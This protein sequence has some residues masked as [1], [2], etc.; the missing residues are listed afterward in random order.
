MKYTA[1]QAAKATGVATSTITNALKSG[2]I[3]GEK[4][5]NG[6]WRIDPAELHRIYPPLAPKGL[7]NSSI[8]RDAIPEKDDETEGL[9]LEVERLREALRGATALDLAK[10]AQIEDLRV[11]LDD[12]AAKADR[13]A[14]ERR[15]LT[16][17]LLDQRPAPPAN[18][19]PAPAPVL[20]TPPA[21]A[22]EPRRGGFWSRL[23]GGGS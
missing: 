22:P 10:Q 2:K 3:S 5:E 13:E 8:E 18:E 12:A 6:A 4:D 7:Q 20:E 14:E 15:K 21:A 19:N 1:G 9:R 16:A 11:R 23:L 17:I